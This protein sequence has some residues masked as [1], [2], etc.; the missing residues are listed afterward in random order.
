MKTIIKEKNE[1]TIIKKSKFIAFIIEIN[2]K[3]EADEI[4]LNYK[5]K[6]K[7]ATHVCYAYIV[8]NIEK[9]SDDGEPSGTAG[10]PMLN[11]L[12]KKDL[13]NVLGIVVRYYGGTPLGANGLIHAY[14][15]SLLKVLDN[16]IVDTYSGYNI[17]FSFDYNLE[18]DINYLLKDA[19]IN[20]KEYKEKIIY[21]IDCNK[22]IYSNLQKKNVRIIYT[23][24]KL[25]KKI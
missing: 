6:Y 17:K 10:M 8:G 22:E 16:N 20:Y 5:N 3:D 15:D 1:I 14:A 19:I 25:I 24:E 4:I 7:D 18:K 11:L 12:K 13:N 2:S 23:G 9:M 21:D